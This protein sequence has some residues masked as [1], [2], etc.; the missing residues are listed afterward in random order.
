MVLH[1]CRYVQAPLAYPRERK[2]RMIGGE[3]WLPFCLYADKNFSNR[4]NPCFWSN[5]YSVNPR[6]PH[7]TKLAP[8]VA[9]FYKKNKV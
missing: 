8:W 9:R 3:N 5:Y 6:K 4:L 7:D 1:N 2:R